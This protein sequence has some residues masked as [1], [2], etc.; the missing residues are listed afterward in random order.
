LLR[1][2]YGQQATDNTSLEQNIGQAI[3]AADSV[4]A[5]FV[6]TSIEATSDKRIRNLDSIMR[7]AAQFAFLLFSQP[8][9][10]SFD[11][12]AQQGRLV[13]FPGLQQTVNEDGYACRPPRVF[14]EPEVVAGAWNW[15]TRSTKWRVKFFIFDLLGSVYAARWFC[16]WELGLWLKVL[17]PRLAAEKFVTE[18]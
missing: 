7:R 4:L 1:G 9:S 17:G 11:W 13:V 2:R 6:N 8:S 16:D 10:F 18:R 12:V 3:V 14:S 5:P 15:F